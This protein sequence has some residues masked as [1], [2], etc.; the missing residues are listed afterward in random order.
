MAQFA[1]NPS[2][3]GADDLVGLL[4][5]H[6]ATAEQGGRALTLLLRPTFTIRS[7]YAVGRPATIGLERPFRLGFQDTLWRQEEISVDG[8]PQR[9]Y[10]GQGADIP[11]FLCV[12]GLRS[13]EGKPGSR[14]LTVRCTYSIALRRRTRLAK[15]GRF[16]RSIRGTSR[17]VRLEGWQPA[18]TYEFDFEIPVEVTLVAAEEA[19]PIE[20]TSSPE[21]GTAVERAFNLKTER[22]GA[23]AALGAMGFDSLNV[24]VYRKLPADIAFRVTVRLSDTQ[25]VA[26]PIEQTQR[27]WAKAGSSGRLSFHPWSISTSRAGAYTGTVTLTSDP[28]VAYEDPTIKTIWDGTLEYPISVTFTTKPE[29]P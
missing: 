18:R 29:V 1:E 11:R 13:G 10:S 19:E 8:W 20:L 6:M 3:A 16:I 17:L 21:L 9:K 7:T 28:N 15:I 26:D 25:G 24:L 4:Q 23:A 12:R 22:F 14:Q 2:Q 5:S 27:L